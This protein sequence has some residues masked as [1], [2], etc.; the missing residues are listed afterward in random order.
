MGG[1]SGNSQSSNNS[2][3]TSSSFGQA[4]PP[5]SMMAS[6]F[7]DM[8]QLSLTDFLSSFNPSMAD[9][10]PSMGAASINLQHSISHTGNF[11]GT[12]HNGNSHSSMNGVTVCPMGDCRGLPV[13]DAAMPFSIDT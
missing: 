1:L 11:Y 9:A 10:M 12:A 6:S 3:D 8:T 4:S 5:P 7:G 13:S 2:S